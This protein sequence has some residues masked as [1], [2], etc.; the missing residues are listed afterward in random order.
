MYLFRFYDKILSHSGSDPVIAA[1]LRY[2]SYVLFFAFFAAAVFFVKN[3]VIANHVSTVVSGLVF[4]AAFFCLVLLYTG[5]SLSVVGNIYTGV[6]FA[7]ILL[8]IIKTGGV[9]SAA[10]SWFV[11][12]VVSSSWYLSG[13]TKYLWAFLGGVAIPWVG[14]LQLFNIISSDI[15]YHASHQPFSESFT[16]VVFYLYALF[17]VL[18]F[19]NI[20]RT[21]R[22]P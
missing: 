19:E 11:I 9:R 22:S 7:V 1:R 13:P 5:R 10:M 20:C 18:A 14:F 3:L 4:L 21:K 2:F 15:P 12:F 6:V 17:N 16:N 8:S